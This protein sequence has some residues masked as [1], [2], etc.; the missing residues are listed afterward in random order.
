[1][2]NTNSVTLSGRLTRDLE[3]KTTPNGTSVVN[4]SIAVTD[5]RDETSFIDIVMF[6]KTAEIAAKYLSKG[7]HL[8]VVGQ[9][10]QR[11]FEAKDG[12]TRSVVEVIVDRLELPPKSSTTPQNGSGEGKDVVLEDISGEPVDLSKLDL[13]F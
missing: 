12:T 4:T 7:S 11:K 13:P 1:M 10:R 3:L 2:A 6:G 9:L 5:Y 8:T